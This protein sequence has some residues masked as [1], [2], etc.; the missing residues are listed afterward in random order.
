MA[1]FG[2]R[3]G[4]FLFFKVKVAE[5]ADLFFWQIYLHSNYETIHGGSLLYISASRISLAAA[6]SNVSELTPWM[7][8]ETFA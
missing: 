3:F 7:G 2:Y 5:D 8:I 4:R 1:R 6:S